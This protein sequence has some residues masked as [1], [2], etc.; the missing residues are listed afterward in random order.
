[1]AHKIPSSPFLYRVEDLTKL[2]RVN[3]L[4][5]NKHIPRQYL[6]ASFDQRLNLLKGLMDTDGTVDADGHTIFYNTNKELIDDTLEL[7]RTLGLKARINE[8]P[9]K[10]NGKNYGSVYEITFIAPFYVFHLPRKTA[11]QKLVQ[12]GTSKRARFHNIVDCQPIDPV[13]MWRIIVNSPSSLYLT[14]KSFVQPLSDRSRLQKF[15][16]KPKTTH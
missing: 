8:K 2:L 5:N 6:R 12:I 11:K 4:R 15:G 13:P 9:A 1:M 16:K 14:E 7:I 3:N 10:F